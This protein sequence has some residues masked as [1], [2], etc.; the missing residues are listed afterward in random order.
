MA[1]KDYDGGFE[2]DKFEGTKQAFL[3][4]LEKTL[5]PLKSNDFVEV[6]MSLKYRKVVKE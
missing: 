6:K 5:S 4:L 2:I 3:H 1:K